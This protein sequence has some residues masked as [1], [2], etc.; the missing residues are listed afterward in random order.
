MSTI[1]C[2]GDLKVMDNDSLHILRT[3]YEEGSVDAYELHKATKIPPTTLFVTLEQ[4]RNKGLVEREVIRY[5]LT[6][7]GEAFFA[8]ELGNELMNPSLS[9]KEVPERF[10]GPKVSIDDISVINKI[11]Q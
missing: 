4:Q 10:S 5:S 9:F 7:K 3:L 2:L 11:V 8:A 1:V 6:E